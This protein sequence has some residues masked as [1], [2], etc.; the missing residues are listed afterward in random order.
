[1]R[2]TLLALF[3]AL[4]ALVAC[5]ATAAGT[6]AAATPRK[7]G[8]TVSPAHPLQGTA[9]TFRTKLPTKVKRPVQLQRKVG[10]TWVRV[11]KGRSKP[12][13]KVVL[14]NVAIPGDSE[15]RVL[16]KAVRKHGEKLRKVVTKPKQLQATLRAELVSAT[17][18]GLSSGVESGGASI[19]ADGR[20]VAFTSSSPT[21][22]P[23]TSGYPPEQTQVLLRDRVDGTTRLVSHRLAAPTLAGTG[24]SSWPRISQDGRYV[25]FVSMSEDLVDDDDQG[26]Q[27]IFRWDRLTG[28]TVRVSTNSIGGDPDGNSYDPSVSAD[29]GVVAYTSAATNIDQDDDNGVNDVFV[30]R[31]S[32]GDSEWISSDV[33]GGDSDD[34]SGSGIVSA[35]GTFVTFSSAAGDLV[36]ND[37]NGH[38][39]VFRRNLAAGTTALVSRGVSTGGDDDTSGGR[40]AVSSDGRFVAF[41]S[42]ADNLVAGGPPDNGKLNVFVRD[43]IA[44]TT[45][46]VSR[47]PDGGATTGHSLPPEWVSE[48]GSRVLYTTIATELVPGDANGAAADALMWSRATGL[49]STVLTNRYGGQPNNAVFE[50]TPSADGRWLAF[51]STA[52]DLVPQD[53]TSA[54]DAYVW[55]MP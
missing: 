38:R 9:A 33:L 53:Q 45:V 6:E 43:M 21:L 11:A 19:S 10:G 42:L 51:Y 47:R 2:R 1:V 36:F 27:D 18:A 50:P 40:S 3:S 44:G 31:A 28:T 22:A 5:L 37:D 17:P 7:P 30:W 12:N 4:L 35:S 55:R 52:T 20:Y 25:V 13:G 32:S 41:A 16:A 39:D 34:A 49:S 15:W 54:T 14:R 8:L 24:A 48:D 23:G 26:H 46:L 29:G